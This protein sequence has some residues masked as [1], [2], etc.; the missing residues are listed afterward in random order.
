MAT[1]TANAWKGWLIWRG[2]NVRVVR[3]GGP[4]RN[5]PN[6]AEGA[7]RCHLSGGENSLPETFAAYR[8][9]PGDNLGA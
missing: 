8:E 2:R 6:L 9:F 1:A 5:R 4:K 7:A 3:F